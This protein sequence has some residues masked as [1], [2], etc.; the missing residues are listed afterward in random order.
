VFEKPR[1]SLRR[2]VG[3]HGAVDSASLIHE[4]LQPPP[5]DRVDFRNARRLAAAEHFDFGPPLARAWPRS[6]ISARCRFRTQV[7]AKFRKFV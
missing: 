6:S 5:P 3:G 1:I 2:I 4:F 7:T